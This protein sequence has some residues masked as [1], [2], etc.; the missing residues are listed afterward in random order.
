MQIGIERQYLILLHQK[1]QLQDSLPLALNFDGEK[2]V[3]IGAGKVAIENNHNAAIA[4][5]FSS[6]MEINLL[7]GAIAALLGVALIIYVK[8]LTKYKSHSVAKVK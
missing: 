6:A 5:I 2:V 7:L 4:H 8:K 1:I 3:M